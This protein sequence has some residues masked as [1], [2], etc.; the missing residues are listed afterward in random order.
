MRDKILYPLNWYYIAAFLNFILRFFWVL[1]LFPDWYFS[2]LFNDAER[3]LLVLSL[4]EI[5][6]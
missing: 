3:I 5:Y 1:T 6:R 4:A 2:E